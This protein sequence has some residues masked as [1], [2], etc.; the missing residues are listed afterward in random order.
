MT[1]FDTSD[2]QQTATKDNHQEVT[3][4][5]LDA[6]TIEL[7]G[8]HLIEASA[9]TGKT[10]NITRI[11]LRLLLEREL[12]V[13]QILLMT[14]T[15]DATQELRGRIDAFIRLALSD[16]DSLCLKDAYFATLAQ[17][18]EKKQREFLLKRALLFLDEAAIF[19]IHGF[20][21]RVLNQYAFTSGL[22]FN[23][24][25]AANSSEITLQVCQDWY[26]SLAKSDHECF[27]L[28]A[29]YWA[30][31]DS[32]LSSFS[33]AIGHTST[34]SVVD[35]ESIEA[36]FIVLVRLAAQTL[37]ANSDLFENGLI[38]VK[39]GADQEKRRDELSQLKIWLES[40]ISKELSLL[41]VGEGKV[42]MP[43]GF[44]D[45]KRYA[46]ST[47]KA[48][49]LEAFAP[50]KEVKEQ[51]KKIANNINKARAYGIVK[52]G[53][54]I[55]RQQ[56]IEQK[57]AL[58]LL[59]FDDLIN[60]LANC[61]QSD[62]SGDEHSQLLAKQLLA[63]YPVAL[64]DEFQDTDPKQFGI[65]QSIYYGD[66]AK[67]ANAGLF[68]IG[69]PKQAI[70]GFRGGD[71]FAYLNARSGCD[72]HWLMDTNWRSTPQMIEGYNQFFTY[73]RNGSS[74]EETV[75]NEVNKQQSESVFGFGI[76]YLP[77]L[78]GKKSAQ[79]QQVI[80]DSD[81]ALQFIH[82]T[83]DETSNDT[84]PQGD[85]VS[86]GSRPMLANWCA[87]EIVTLLASKEQTGKVNPKDIAILV[88]DGAEA[89]DIKHALQQA[90]LDSVFLSDRAN[91]FHSQQAKQLLGLLKGVLLPENERLF[92][93]AL[94]CGLL[95]FDAKKLHQLQQ[96]EMAYQTLKFAFVD[97]R[98]QWQRQ[99][100]I[101]MAI[102]LMHNLLDVPQN[103]KD[104]CL[105]NVLHL[106]EILQAASVRLSQ[107]QELLHWFEQ[108]CHL[109]TNDVEAELR[110]E[111]D[112][113]L[114]RLITQHGSKGLEY[115]YVFIPF[116]CRHKDPL[117]FGNKSVSYLEY[118]DANGKLCLSLDGSKEAKKAMSNEAYAESI[119]LLYVAI[120]RAERR[121][122]VLCCAFDAYHL[123]PLGKTLQFQEQESII[124]PLQVLKASA[125]HAIGIR[126]VSL[127]CSIDLYL[128]K[129]DEAA[130][131]QPK[132][133]PQEFANTEVSKFI[134]K[135]ERDWWLSSFTALSRNIR[136]A[137]V[138]NPDRDTTDIA[139]RQLDTDSE[140]TD[141]EL[142][143]AEQICFK[144]S[145]GAHTGNLLHD[146]L[147]QTDFSE[148]DWQESLEKPL[149]AYGEL[150]A[151]NA[152]SISTSFTSD[153][154]IQWLEQVISAPFISSHHSALTTDSENAGCL[155]DIAFNRTL[156]ESEFYFPM[157][158]EGTNALANLLT[159][160]RNRA[161]RT[162]TG[163]SISTGRNSGISKTLNNTLK[164][165]VM[166]PSYKKLSGMMHG[167]IDLIFEYQGKYYLCDY[168]SSH[169][170][171]SFQD[172]QFDA[173][174]D[175]V[176]KNYYDLQY[177]IY[178]LALH[179]YLKQTLVDYD[180]NQHFGG[181]YYLYL[182]GMTTEPEHKGAGVYYRKITEQEINNLD[183]LFS[184]KESNEKCNEEA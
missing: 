181:V 28:L 130:L 85:K 15:K 110:L 168:K 117:K 97:Y 128:E 158:G 122:Y 91:L 124:K 43:D 136:H 25:M 42:K 16:W 178:S 49:L 82:F 99:G 13:E 48:E 147:E 109:E 140:H 36:E 53:I 35:V 67:K 125:E 132:N 66:N 98:T 176:E 107:G 116:A 24:N 155:A 44:F 84:N 121:C 74:S 184:N 149:L 79:A 61:L 4:Q 2:S 45:G 11:Y 131:H 18:I 37:T 8:K 29:S 21:Q 133:S 157:Q 183:A 162:D 63:Q 75:S 166:L 58:N 92:V 106:F 80:L 100:F 127:D 95:G 78:A 39:K 180:V 170:G 118:H 111:S 120:T 173:L 38:L 81:K 169:L 70:Y 154:L 172:Y 103:N 93:A 1:Q 114:I 119:R 156:R 77:V 17:R 32:F 165:P 144:L 135:I 171:D 33:K 30:T 59:D 126:E 177:L 71:I 27:M 7:T 102:N 62:S 138:S 104:R 56:V 167:F 50:V 175:N 20:C 47:Y 90:G 182:R 153:D 5:N 142:L 113:D 41:D 68:L 87:N 148:P 88:R 34:L 69:D 83:N 164:Y 163:N 31:P 161:E 60:T 150:N 94:S 73:K 108:Q 65:L 86:Q 152:N 57:K 101:T 112:G 151:S 89:R 10:Y 141:I 129:N 96:D 105:T 40:I 22:P 54:Y 23:A 159:D 143:S 145:K 115:P 179:R 134:G 174:L 6:A 123:S 46:R 76:P 12:T 160:H 9:G 14:F 51:V 3:L 137:G 139:N 26:R 19:T 52:S 72:H 146:I 64:I 55:I